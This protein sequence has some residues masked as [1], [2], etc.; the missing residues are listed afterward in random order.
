MALPQDSHVHLKI[1]D[2][3]KDE[4]YEFTKVLYHVSFTPGN[5]PILDWNTGVWPVA[6]Y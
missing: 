2:E 5:M 6:E 3:D 1:L 4:V